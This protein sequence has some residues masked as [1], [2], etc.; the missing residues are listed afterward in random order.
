M[1]FKLLLD[2]GA[3]IHARD[4]R[5]MTCL[6]IAVQSARPRNHLNTR[7]EED[8]EAITLLTQRGADIFTTD[9]SGRSIFDDAYVCDHEK[10]YPR[11]SYRGDL[12]DAAL[13]RC[14][15]GE[16]IQRP[17]E[18]MC[19]YTQWYT[20]EEFARLW[21]GMAQDCPYISTPSAICPDRDEVNRRA[22]EY[23]RRREEYIRH[24]EANYRRAEDSVSEEEEEDSADSNIGDEMY[25]TDSEQDGSEIGY[26]GGIVLGEVDDLDGD[27]AG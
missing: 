15:H 7:V 4:N 17:E 14:G 16:H 8:M 27:D 9:Y 3:N 20:E 21:E 18:R 24:Y 1:R 22:E 12:W 23:N 13:F 26:R 25:L 2:R 5:G 6:H 10:E 19:H 11:G